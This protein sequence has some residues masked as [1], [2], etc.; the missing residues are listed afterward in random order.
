MEAAIGIPYI[1]R[2]MCKASRQAHMIWL[3]LLWWDH[4][5]AVLHFDVFLSR[6]STY[7]ISSFLQVQPSPLGIARLRLM[8]HVMF[9]ESFCFDFTK[10][11]TT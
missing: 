9:F 7:N 3:E 2:Y 6:E 11:A 5:F 8:A 4:V 10:G 1:T